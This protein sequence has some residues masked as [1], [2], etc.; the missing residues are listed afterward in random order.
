M[1]R[2]ATIVLTILLAAVLMVLPAMAAEPPTA[3]IESVSGIPGETVTMTV[4]L[5]GFDKEVSLAVQ[6]NADGLEYQ[7]AKSQWY[8]DGDMTGTEMTWEG[9]V[10]V[11]K[12]A[13]NV[14]TDVLDLAFTI[15]AD[16]K[17]EMP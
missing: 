14:N 8:L 11:G 17:F 9:I 6:V 12:K 15:P 10:W 16:A 13:V 5:Q 3:S 4:S 1:K 7:P 2:I